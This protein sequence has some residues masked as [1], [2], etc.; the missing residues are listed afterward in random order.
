MQ[1]FEIVVWTGKRMRGSKVHAGSGGHFNVNFG[2]TLCGYWA[3]ERTTL[4]ATAD[5][6]TCKTCAAALKR[7]ADERA[8]DSILRRAM[9][10][11]WN[12]IAADAIESCR[13]E[14]EPFDDENAYELILDAS[15]L[16]EYGYGYYRQKD[17]VVTAAIEGFRKL[18]WTQQVALARRLLGSLV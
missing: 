14:G 7:D 10:D 2:G 5:A 1:A 12:A 15:R 6:V 9:Q 13:S 18:N 4:R 16:E 11:T 3:T 8:K 17:P